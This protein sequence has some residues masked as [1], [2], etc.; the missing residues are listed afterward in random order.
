MATV[1]EQLRVLTAGV[2][3]LL[4]QDGLAERL[5]AARAESR[6]LRVKLGIDPSSSHLTLGTPWCCASSPSSS[7]SGTR[8]C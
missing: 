5:A 2:A 8:W 4:P 1:E 3:E 6:P 7:V